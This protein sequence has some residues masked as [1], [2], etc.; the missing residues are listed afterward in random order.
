MP[1]VVNVVLQLREMQQVSIIFVPSPQFQEDNSNIVHIN[2]FLCV[3]IA[4]QS[5]VSTLLILVTCLHL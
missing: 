5:L 4:Q 2:N 3:C 1:S